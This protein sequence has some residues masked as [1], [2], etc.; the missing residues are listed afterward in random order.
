[1]IVCSFAIVIVRSLAVLFCIVAL[2]L[3]F[4]LICVAFA[5]LHVCCV[6]RVLFCCVFVMA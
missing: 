4:F 2:P 1:M 3:L 5:G 6:G